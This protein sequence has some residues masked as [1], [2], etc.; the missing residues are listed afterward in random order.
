MRLACVLAIVFAG[1]AGAQTPAA[2]APPPTIRNS[3]RVPA[4]PVKAGD[5]KGETGEAPLNTPA[6]QPAAD[7]TPAASPVAAGP[8]GGYLLPGAVLEIELNRGVDSGRQHNGDSVQGVLTAPVR[9]VNGTVLAKGTPV[10]ATILSSAAAGTMQSYGVLSLQVYR[11]GGFAV[12][13][14]VLDFDGQ[15]GHKDLPDSA[16]AKG[17]EAA[18]GAGS[19]LR[20]K[21]LGAGDQPDPTEHKGAAGAAGGGR[22]VGQ[23]APQVGTQ[24]AP[25]ATSPGPGTQTPH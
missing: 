4:A 15:E 1:S 16:P 11:V 9:A 22:A 8:R 12:F 21:V 5:D 2:P 6:E 24:A 14:N 7:V 20:F 25:Q 19:T 13:T 17:T 10:E 3:T 18:V 23:G